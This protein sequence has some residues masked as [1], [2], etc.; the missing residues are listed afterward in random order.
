M[1]RPMS[2]IAFNATGG[3]LDRLERRGLPRNTSAFRFFESEFSRRRK[4]RTAQGQPPL[5]GP[6]EGATLRIRRARTTATRGLGSGTD[7]NTTLG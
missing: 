4:Q 1:S 2:L 6:Q 5:T 3:N 7:D